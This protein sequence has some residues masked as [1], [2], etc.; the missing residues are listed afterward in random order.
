MPEFIA[1]TCRGVFVMVTY[2]MLLSEAVMGT[3]LGQGE[4]QP[5]SRP[6]SKAD[7]QKLIE[8]FSIPPLAKVQRD[9][10]PLFRPDPNAKHK[11]D[12][13]RAVL[14]AV[15]SIVA[16]EFTDLKLKKAY[17]SPSPQFSKDHLHVLFYTGN[18]RHADIYLQFCKTPQEAGE[19]IRGLEVSSGESYTPVPGC[20]DE[21]YQYGKSGT[22]L[23]CYSNIYIMVNGDSGQ[24]KAQVG[25]AVD[26]ALKTLVGGAK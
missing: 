25:R 20:G 12:E 10:S 14:D 17:L 13:F 11:R 15:E 2:C 22:F 26:K 19:R 23:M 21:A 8:S 3:A 9:P 7:F 18:K 5:I 1:A 16:K 4:E 24:T 6:I